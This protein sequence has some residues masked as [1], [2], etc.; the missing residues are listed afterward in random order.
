MAQKIIRSWERLWKL[1]RRAGCTHWNYSRGKLRFRTMTRQPYAIGHEIP[2]SAGPPVRVR[3]YSCTDDEFV[4]HG[5]RT[6][7]FRPPT[8]SATIPADFATR[9]PK[10]QAAYIAGLIAMLSA[11]RFAKQLSPANRMLLRIV[12]GQHKQIATL[13]GLIAEL[14]HR[15]PEPA[16]TK[17]ADSRTGCAQAPPDLGRQQGQGDSGAATLH[18]IAEL[19]AQMQQRKG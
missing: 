7:M 16:R 4:A 6:V 2:I 18:A 15:Q 11:P 12:T 5:E 9:L 14:Q 19:L 17:P 1:A 3:F 13:E 10:D 8:T